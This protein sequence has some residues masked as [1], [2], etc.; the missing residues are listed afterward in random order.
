MSSYNTPADTSSRS[1]AGYNQVQYPPNLGP[2]NPF[3]DPSESAGAVSPNTTQAAQ[4]PRNN[5]SLD[6]L[7][8]FR[9]DRSVRGPNPVIKF[10]QLLWNWFKS[11]M[12]WLFGPNTS[13]WSKVAYGVFMY[14]LGVMTLLAYYRLFM[15]CRYG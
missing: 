6:A 13:P 2:V 9:A 1:E 15:V 5:T 10:L 3:L 4:G 12:F 14:I 7:P 11:S 8:R